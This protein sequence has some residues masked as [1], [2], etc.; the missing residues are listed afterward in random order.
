MFHQLLIQDHYTKMNKIYFKEEQKFGS[1]LLYLIM[2]VIYAIPI[3]IFLYA[4]YQQF[5]LEQQW[6]DKPMSDFGLLLTSILVFAI[7]IISGFLLFGSKLAVEVSNKSLQFTFKPFVNKPIRYFKSDIKRYEIRK[8]KPIKEY[9][10]WGIKQGMKSIGRAYNVKG[11][12]GLQLYLNNGKK[13]L[14]GTQR[15]EALNRAMRKMMD[16][17]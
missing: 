6:S 9:G 5:V 16:I 4:F 1:R 17:N 3:V 12:I 10:G 11:N 2:G 8:Y 13:V 15:G 7:I 14:I